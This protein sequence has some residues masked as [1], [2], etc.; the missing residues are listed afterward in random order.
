MILYIRFYIVE[1]NASTARGT[2]L[3][4]FILFKFQI[5]PNFVWAPVDCR[6]FLADWLPQA[7]NWVFIWTLA[8]W[9]VAV[10]VL[11]LVVLV[12]VASLIYGW[13][14]DVS[15][16]VLYRWLNISSLVLNWWLDVST[17]VLSWWLNISSLIL[18][19][20]LSR[21]LLVLNLWRGSVSLSPTG[22]LL[23]H[24]EFEF[25]KLIWT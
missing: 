15:S 21:Y 18:Y 24:F 2:N 22:N 13:R 16:L 1:L 19:R 9:L 17:L 5:A 6:I 3:A 4:G 7:W 20:W 23:I 11:I 8:R 25:D 10:L 14:L 12:V